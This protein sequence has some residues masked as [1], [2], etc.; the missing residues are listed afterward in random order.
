MFGVK[1]YIYI[2]PAAKLFSVGVRRDILR[3]VQYHLSVSKQTAYMNNLP[4]CI[5][6]CIGEAFDIYEEGG[7][8]ICRKGVC[9][10]FSYPEA[11]LEDILK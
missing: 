8:K 7:Q 2:V 3:A 9:F 10:H 5:L 1:V 11:N 4:T 6:S